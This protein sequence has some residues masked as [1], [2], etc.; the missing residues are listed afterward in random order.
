M[1]HVV[2]FSGGRTSAYLV[3]LMEQKRKSEGW[4]VDYVFMDT[5]AEH[6]KTYEF[7]R[8][9]VDHFGIKLHCIRAK[10]NKEHGVGVTYQ[11]L[12]VNEIGWDLSIWESFVS[13]S[14]SKRGL[15][16]AVRA[17]VNFAATS[18]VTVVIG[19]SQKWFVSRQNVMYRSQLKFSHRRPPVLRVFCL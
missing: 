7:V 18:A 13:Q 16:K 1:K 10:V 2:S 12:S 4:D 19:I 17:W 15:H 11:E 3:H 6:P 14:R 5:G 9:V 8:N